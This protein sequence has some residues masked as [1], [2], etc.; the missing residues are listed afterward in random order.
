M[1]FICREVR[2]PKTDAEWFFYK[3]EGCG[4]K[5]DG[6]PILDWRM[7]VRAWEKIKIFPSQKVFVNGRQQPPPKTVTEQVAERYS[8]IADRL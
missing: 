1:D 2:L 3:C 6:K 4:W 7:T 5:N 8:K